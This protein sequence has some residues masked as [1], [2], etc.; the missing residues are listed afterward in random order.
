MLR[1]LTKKTFT[2]NQRATSQLSIGAYFFAYRSCEYPKGQYTEKRWTDILRLRY[3]RF[4]KGGRVLAHNNPCLEYAD[5]VSIT[6]EWQKKDVREDT[7]TQMASKDM[8]LCIVRQWAAVVKRITRY[9]GATSD[10]PVSA[11]W[12]NGKLDNI[13]AKEI[14]N[15]L[16]T[17][18]V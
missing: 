2:E 9:A 17:A 8:L 6:F 4:K 18:V 7:V 1:E 5:S 14:A 10:T 16:K 13:T 12:R 15:A 3:V 11:V